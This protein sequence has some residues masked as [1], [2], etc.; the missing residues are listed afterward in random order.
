MNALRALK[1]L[2]KMIF[3]RSGSRIFLLGGTR[4]DYAS[5][6]GD[7]TGSSTVMAPLL[8]ITRTFP[9]AP[10]AL[11]KE[12]END[13]ETQVRQHAML[14]LLARPNHFYSGPILWMATLLDWNVDGNAYWLKLR[15]N[16]GRGRVS[17][18][19]WTPHWT[20]EPKGD[21]KTFLTHYEYR[22]SGG[23]EPVRVDVEDVVHFRFGLDGDDPRKGYSPLKSVL[24]EVWTDDEAANF[25][26]TLLRNMGV[27]GIL[28]SPKSASEPNEEDV[29]EIK[30]AFQAK[31]SGDRR[32]EPMVLSAPTDIEQFGFSPEQLLLRDLRRIPEER[33]TAALG[34][35]AIVAGLGAGLDRSTFTNMGEAREMAYEN[36]IIPSQRILAEDL[37]FQLLNEYED[38]PFVWRVGFDLSKVRTLQEDEDKR[39]RRYDVGYRGGWVMRSESRRAMGLTVD[40]ERDNVYLVPLNV[41]E[42]PAD[43]SAPRQTAPLNGNGNGHAEASEIATAVAQELERDQLLKR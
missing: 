8:W 38:D 14:R 17:E 43:G 10:A 20:L 5:K 34:V 40:N 21:E 28:L 35:P 9:E 26:A 42:V 7:G 25:T 13:E 6:V 3:S 41:T 12:D 15:D 16:G 32:G 22:P 2:T 37:R 19:W 27:P 30:S 24:R 18:L 39:L 1:R 11:W 4:Y 23:L 31:F 33:V 36:N 29:A